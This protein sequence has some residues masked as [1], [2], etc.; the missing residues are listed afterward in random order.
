LTK[1]PDSPELLNNLAGLLA[2]GPDKSLHNPARALALAGRAVALTS[3]KNPA[4]LDT[5]ASAQAAGGDF[6]GAADTAAKALT[7]AQ[8]TGETALIP[9]LEKA[10]SAYRAGHRPQ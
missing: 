6:T 9:L 4:L 10:L 3:G 8:T 2:T 7:L 1:S 5:L